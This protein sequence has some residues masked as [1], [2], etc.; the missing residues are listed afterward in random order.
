MT[1]LSGRRVLITREAED[2]R[3]WARRLSSAGAVPIVFPC[4]TTE[5]IACRATIELVHAALARSEWLALSSARGAEVAARLIEVPLPMHVRVATVGATTA[6]VAKARLGRVDLVA[7]PPTGAALGAELSSRLAGSGQHVLVIGA[8]NGRTDVESALAAAGVAFTRVDV[9]R[10][11]PVPPAIAPRDL[12]ADGV[13]DILLASPSAVSGLC[14]AAAIPASARIITIG[15]T[16]TSAAR[17]AGL[18]VWAE[19][20]H[21]SLEG[22]LEAIQ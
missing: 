22:M 10:T 5:P 3:R 4:I 1:P 2:S 7:D 15:P 20:R 18:D 11:L 19:A 12:A 17:A 13:Q 8:E 16:T 9:Y 14:N 21:P 6:H